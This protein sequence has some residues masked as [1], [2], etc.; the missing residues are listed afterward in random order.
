MSCCSL[1]VSPGSFEMAS[2]ETLPITFDATSLLLTGESISVASAE[3]VQMDTGIDYSA[4]KLG[5]VAV[6]GAQVTQTVTGL[7]PRKRYRLTIQF[8]VAVNKTWAP[9]LVIEC[10]E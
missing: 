6:A 2:Q 3:L 9:Y 1:A 7:V 8:T 5:P 10:P 4:G